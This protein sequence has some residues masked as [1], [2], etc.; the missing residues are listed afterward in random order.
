MTGTV[1]S[2]STTSLVINVTSVTGSGTGTAW[3]IAT[4]EPGDGQSA[5]DAQSHDATE[6]FRARSVSTFHANRTVALAAAYGLAAQLSVQRERI[7]GIEVTLDAWVSSA[8]VS[9]LFGL[10][11]GDAAEVVVDHG[12][13]DPQVQTETRFI[14]GAEHVIAGRSHKVR[15]TLGMVPTMNF[16]AVLKQAG[17]VASTVGVAEYS[18][19]DDGMID[20][21]LYLSGSASGSAGNAI[22]VESTDLPDPDTGWQYGIGHF[23]YL[24]PGVVNYGGAVA[25]NGTSFELTAHGSTAQLG[26]DPSF[27]IASGHLLSIQFRFKPAA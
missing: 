27:A 12:V 13:G 9:S 11:I 25:W 5:F 16:T 24:R 23:Y 26:T 10:E 7:T 22:T 1:T 2:C 3:D 18:V 17:T 4:T 6:Q 21:R 8:Q 14:D 20:G 15:L 19:G